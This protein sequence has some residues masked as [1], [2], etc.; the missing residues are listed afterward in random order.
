MFL[1]FRLHRRYRLDGVS[2]PYELRRGRDCLDFIPHTNSLVTLLSLDA[3]DWL[4]FPHFGYLW[5]RVNCFAYLAGR[6]G[7]EAAPHAHGVLLRPSRE[8]DSRC[9]RLLSL[10]STIKLLLT[11]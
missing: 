9:V 1:A 7:V 11:M 2:L 8:V 3:L 4:R 6:C 10:V 5:F